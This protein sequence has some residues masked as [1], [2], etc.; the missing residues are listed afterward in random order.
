MHIVVITI[1]G[2]RVL[3]KGMRTM[4][5]AVI[6]H[7][8]LRNKSNEVVPGVMWVCSFLCYSSLSLTF[9]VSSTLTFNDSFKPLILVNFLKNI[10]NNIIRC[11]QEKNML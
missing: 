10:F 9:N 8:Q 3:N 4:V 11:V 7:L 1:S 2:R 5:A 6:V